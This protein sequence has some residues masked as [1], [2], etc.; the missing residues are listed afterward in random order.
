MQFV[1]Q[2]PASSSL[3]PL[4]PKYLI[5]TSDEEPCPNYC[6]ILMYLSQQVGSDQSLTRSNLSG[7][8]SVTGAQSSRPQLN[9][10][11]D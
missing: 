6:T 10:S 8:L 11:H 4:A 7:R 3:V 5:S 2:R 9:L 1:R